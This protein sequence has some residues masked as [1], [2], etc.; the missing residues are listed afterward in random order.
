MRQNCTLV[1]YLFLFVSVVSF[2]LCH[3]TFPI[4]LSMCLY[5]TCTLSHHHQE[6]KNINMDSFYL[7]AAWALKVSFQVLLEPLFHQLLFNGWT[8]CYRELW[9]FFPYFVSNS[10]VLLPILLEVIYMFVLDLVL[11]CHPLN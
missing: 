5:H 1:T 3:K 11:E 10:F 7:M 4:C 2:H 6:I 8:S 9:F